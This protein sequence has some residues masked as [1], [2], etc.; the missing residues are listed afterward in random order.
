MVFFEQIELAPPDPILGLAV[1]F[2]AD[3]R[4]YKVNLSVGV[5]KTADLNTPILASVK[6]AEADL[7]IS[8]KNKNYLPIDGDKT[9]L[10]EVGILIFGKPFWETSSARIAAIQGVGGTGSLRLGMDFLKQEVNDHL[11]YSKPTW[12]NHLQM[13]SKVGMITHAYPYYDVKNHCFEFDKMVAFLEKLT[14]KSILLLHAV[15]HNPTGAD[16]TLEQWKLLSDLFLTKQLFPFFDFAYQG[17]AKGIEEDAAA[18]RLFAE[19]GHEM[20]VANSFSK[21][22]GLYGER[23]GGL[24]VVTHSDQ[25][26]VH[27]TSQLKVLARTHY[28]N[29]PMHGAKIIAH[30]LKDPLLKKQ[31]EEELTVMRQHIIKMKEAL[32][33]QLI[34]K[35][36]KRDFSFLKERHGLFCFCG[37]A[38]G[39]VD[40]LISEYGI[41]MTE[42]GRINVV[43]LNKDNLDYVV[44]AIIH[45]SEQ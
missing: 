15:C 38:K 37:L 2:N 14:P 42:D 32:T 11:Y 33:A 34:L 21:N 41:Y 5:Y 9:Y 3:K 40:R 35:S 26:A 27:I 6:Q 20:V 28:S 13:S 39:E 10:N 19:A 4:S 16:P 17:F 25:T 22:F 1:A 24:F 8:E 29:P 18:I 23:A 36:K 30:I 7:W 12:V 43:G 44:N 31:W 45:V